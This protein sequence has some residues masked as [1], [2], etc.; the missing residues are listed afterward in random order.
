MHSI[1]A[2]HTS[3]F[4]RLSQSLQFMLA[5]G[6]HSNERYEKLSI[7]P[8]VCIE[9]IWVNQM[10]AR[11]T[12]PLMQEVVRVA[13]KLPND[14]IS[15]PLIKYMTRHIAE[16]MDHDQWYADDLEFLG[17]PREEIFARLPIPNVAAMVGSQYYWINHHHPVSFMGYLAVLEVNHPTEEYVNKLIS[18]SKLPAKGFSTVMEHAVVD[19]QHSKDIIETLNNLPLNEQQFRMIE[20]S[21]FQTFRYVSLI[22]EDICRVAGKGVTKVAI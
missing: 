9:H 16:E 11:A 10:V 4:E 7:Y 13:E 22:V 18:N 14:P 2:K 6:Q 19:V 12:V 3:H 20:R 1:D 17:I 5:K 15:A 21:A 8:E